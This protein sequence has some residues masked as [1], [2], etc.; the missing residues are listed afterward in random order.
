MARSA[1]S[2]L[3]PPYL[4]RATLLPERV[5]D[6]SRHPFDLP[7]FT[8]RQFDLAFRSP[9]TVIVGENG[10]GKSTLLEAIAGQI[11]FAMQSGTRNFL[12]QEAPPV[13]S[14]CL[15]LAWLPR[16]T[17]GFFLRAE[18][19]FN[20]IT[21]MDEL[22]REP[23]P[24]PRIAEAYGGRS[25]HTRSHGEAFLALF[26]NR[27]AGGHGIYILDE[28]EAALSPQ[29]QIRFLNILSR[30]ERAG[31][32]QVIIASHAPL[33]IGYPGADLLIMEPDGIRRGRPEDTSHWRVVRDYFA[34]PDGF[35]RAAVD[36]AD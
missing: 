9:V 11:G 18:S 19:Y 13:L 29:R 32:S 33:I 36:T 15:R 14:R 22:D 1:R 23:A 17:R 26:E 21:Q 16:V 34:D 35:M 7:L 12:S 2:H 27:F 25:L 24:A 20:F 4:K 3:P 30:M 31:Q 8:G 28:P 5:E 6:W 10:V